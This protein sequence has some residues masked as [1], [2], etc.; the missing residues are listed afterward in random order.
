MNTKGKNTN[1]TPFFDRPTDATATNVGEPYRDLFRQGSQE[2][3]RPEFTPTP[4]AHMPL[5]SLLYFALFGSNPG[6]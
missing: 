2:E 3:S 4:L 6:F 1:V 5:N